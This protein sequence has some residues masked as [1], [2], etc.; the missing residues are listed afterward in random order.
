MQHV[1]SVAKSLAARNL[2]ACF[3]AFSV[4]SKD[5]KYLIQRITCA[6]V[7]RAFFLCQGPTIRPLV[8]TH[9]PKLGHFFGTNLH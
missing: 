8:T 9:L 4:S 1:K 5:S 7:I 6:P 3:N 2:E